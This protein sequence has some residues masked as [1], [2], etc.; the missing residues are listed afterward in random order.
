[1]IKMQKETIDKLSL[2]VST[3]N[4]FKRE[5][6][7]FSRDREM[8]F[9]VFFLPI[10]L[11][12]T[13]LQ[14]Y[15]SGALHKL[16]VAVFDEDRSELS[17]QMKLA[18]QSSSSMDVVLFAS[19]IAEIK[20]AL[21]SGKI[22]GA[23]Y[24]PSHMESD[25]KSNKQVNP[26]LFK[27]SQ[28]VISSGFLLK[29]GLSIFRTFNGGILLKKLRSKGLTEQQAMAI[30]KPIN[31]DAT[32]LYNAGFNYRNFLC[33]GIIFAQLQLIFM[34]AGVLLI[35]REFDRHSFKAAYAISGKRFW[36][37]ILSKLLMMTFWSA[38]VVLFITSIL[39]RCHQIY[40]FQFFT[41][42]MVAA[43]YNAASILFG[44]LIGTLLRNT[45][46]S[47]EI[48]IFLSIPAFMLSGYSYPLW[49][50]PDFM[51]LFSK[52]LPFTYFFTAWFKIAQMNT[53]SYYA[54]GEVTGLLIIA[55]VSFLIILC[56]N[57]N[58]FFRKAAKNSSSSFKLTKSSGFVDIVLRELHIIATN[59]CLVM[60]LFAGPAVYPF[61]Y[62]SI[63]MKKFQRDVPVTVVD[64]DKSEFSRK[65]TADIEAHE[66]LRVVS[67]E[68][69][70][71]IAYRQLQT[72]NTMAIVIIPEGYQSKLKKNRQ[73]NIHASINNTRF[74]IASDINRALGD[75]ISNTSRGV[76]QDAFQKSGFNRKQARILSEPIHLTINNC[77]NTTESYGDSMISALFI[78]ILHQTLLIGLALSMAAEREDRKLPELLSLTKSSAFN[79]VAAKGIFYVI[80]YSS[81]A[82]L[83]FT[84]HTR[85]YHVPLNGPY[86]GLILLCF[87]LFCSVIP[88]SLFLASFFKT[89][90]MTL[91]VFMVSSYPI[92][93]LSGYSWPFEGLP[94]YLQVISSFLPTTHFFKAYAVCT[95]MGCNTKEVFPE[96]FQIALL[97]LLYFVLFQL[98]LLVIS[99]SGTTQN[100][101]E[102]SLN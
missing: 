22:L 35:T 48:A 1:M 44:M 80:L 94:R 23:F 26:V 30:I 4:C 102:K 78:I 5:V 27:N 91:I 32:V 19:S 16:P 47:I 6:K 28:S 83:F 57:K 55:A 18:I 77:F 66:L 52:I 3:V 87:L 84:L 40:I 59:P 69:N 2:S 14:I 41:A 95:S 43:I 24:F 60:I 21:K 70:T 73:T 67:V 82:L 20:A 64:L 89:R 15:G 99:K 79:T 37:V 31:V 12:V 56:F 11:S 49:A 36:M 39:F 61:L 45:L 90:L 29:E 17:G 33:P 97:G 10:I 98:R 86:S 71:E 72:F 75:I 38:V 62:N 58:H 46:L 51:A 63:Y 96:A 9:L 88:M 8:L 13:L 65:L 7:R 93:F 92:F 34:I 50:V 68:Q 76:I 100:E 81:Y 74:M 42:I 101:A 53:T 25:V 54:I 85:L